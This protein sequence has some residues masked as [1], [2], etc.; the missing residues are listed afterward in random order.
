MTVGPYRTSPE[1]PV[2]VLD[3]TYSSIRCPACDAENPVLDPST[4]FHWSEKRP[5]VFKL[6]FSHFHWSCVRCKFDFLMRV[7]NG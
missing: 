1:R 6:S 7:T 4:C 2:T 3:F 5:C